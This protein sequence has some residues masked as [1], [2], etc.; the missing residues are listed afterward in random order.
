[1]AELF[2][3]LL[4]QL[5][6]CLEEFSLLVHIIDFIIISCSLVLY[7]IAIK[8]SCSILILIGILVVSILFTVM[9]KTAIHCVP[10]YDCQV[11]TASSTGFSSWS[12]G[13]AN[14]K[15]PKDYF[16]PSASIKAFSQTKTILS[17]RSILRTA[18]KAI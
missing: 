11:W 5:V 2:H 18:V 9:K 13:S 12:F 6:I 1:M 3:S 8:K 15:S 16:L 17:L 14:S 4:F 10:P 7:G